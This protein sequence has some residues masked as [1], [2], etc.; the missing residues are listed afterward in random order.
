M[1]YGHANGHIGTVTNKRRLRISPERHAEWY[2]APA[3]SK[4]FS[5]TLLETLSFRI[6]QA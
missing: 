3:C 2:G 4:L 6:H 5:Y 1:I